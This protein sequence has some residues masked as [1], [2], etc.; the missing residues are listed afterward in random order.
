M[1]VLLYKRFL[2]AG[3]CLELGDHV[4]T[5]QHL[6]RCTNIDDMLFKSAHKMNR[7]LHQ[8]YVHYNA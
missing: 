6:S 4:H 5:R 1:I 8:M 3:R 7:I 2:A